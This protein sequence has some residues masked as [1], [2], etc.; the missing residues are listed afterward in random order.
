MLEYLSCC[1]EDPEPV[2][3]Q[4]RLLWSVNLDCSIGYNWLVIITEKP[5]P[6]AV[7]RLR[8]K[9]NL[10][11]VHCT[12]THKIL[13][14]IYMFSLSK[15]KKKN[16]YDIS[17]S[18]SFHWHS[19]Y[20]FVGIITVGQQSLPRSKFTTSCAFEGL[21]LCISFIMISN[22]LIAHI[23]FWKLHSPKH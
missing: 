10:L 6:S 22:L 7:D 20:F 3:G 5:L 14:I 13:F 15:K 19:V 21:S 17:F 11:L 2:I 23:Y 8:T 9:I 18:C 1:P 4:S 12:H 16:C